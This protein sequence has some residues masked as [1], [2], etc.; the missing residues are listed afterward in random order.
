[1]ATKRTSK[2]FVVAPLLLISVLASQAL[3]PAALASGSSVPTVP[4]HVTLRLLSTHAVFVTWL[5]PSNL[6]GQPAISYTVRAENSGY[7]KTCVTTRLAC[8]FTGLTAGQMYAFWLIAH[9]SYGSSRSTVKTYIEMIPGARQQT[10]GPPRTTTSS[11]P[12]VQLTAANWLVCDA[13]LG[14]TIEFDYSNGTAT[15]VFVNAGG[16]GGVFPPTYETIGNPGGTQF[17]YYRVTR[18]NLGN[19]I[20][21]GGLAFY[22]SNAYQCSLAP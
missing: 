7:T 14:G 12:Q 21:G 17:G 22:V 3:T 6:K 19:L 8:R 5:P 13:P 11:R 18:D 20:P 4:R 16:Y 15:R 2:T 9:N 10:P 1:M